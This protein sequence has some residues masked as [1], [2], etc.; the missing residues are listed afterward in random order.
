MPSQDIAKQKA[1]MLSSDFE[2]R[3]I[4]QATHITPQERKKLTETATMVCKD[5]ELLRGYDRMV[6]GRFR[7]NRIREVIEKENGVVVDGYMRSADGTGT[8]VKATERGTERK[9]LFELMPKSQ[10]ESDA[11]F[12]EYNCGKEMVAKA[13]DRMVIQKTNPPMPRDMA[14]HLQKSIDHSSWQTARFGRCDSKKEAVK[15]PPKPKH[16]PSFKRNKLQLLCDMPEAPPMDDIKNALKLFEDLQGE[17]AGS[18]PYKPA[19]LAQRR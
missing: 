12:T 10:K 18:V 13:L 11:A 4:N 3:L 1:E 15:E 6:E 19:N 16:P 7:I 9:V 5:E 17:D 14:E 8:I 2:M